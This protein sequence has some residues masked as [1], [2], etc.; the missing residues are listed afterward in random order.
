MSFPKTCMQ[1]IPGNRQ[2]HRLSLV[3]VVP[4]RQ[5][6]APSGHRG[7]HWPSSQQTLPC[8]QQV[9][10]QQASGEQQVPPQQ[11]L[12]AAQQVFSLQQTPDGQQVPLQQTLPCAQDMPQPPQLF[13]S[14]LVSTHWPLQR[15]NGGAHTHRPF[16]HAS[17][18][19]HQCPQVP[20]L[21]RSLLVSTHIVPHSFSGA[22]QMGVHPL[23]GTAVGSQ[24]PWAEAIQ[25]HFVQPVVESLS[26]KHGPQVPH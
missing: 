6:D 14:L 20:Q 12:P 4:C 18:A 15:L 9:P 24:V 2:Q 3:H 26:W 16:W 19:A 5:Q 10:L 1:L 7:P 8:A 13:G 22:V 21:L 17:L 23:H 25:H 11:T